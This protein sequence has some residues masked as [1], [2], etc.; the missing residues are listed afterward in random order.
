M[1][2]TQIYTSNIYTIRTILLIHNS[3]THDCIIIKI[4]KQHR[5]SA[6]LLDPGKVPIAET[7]HK[8]KGREVETT[9]PSQYY[10]IIYTFNY[11][12]ISHGN[13]TY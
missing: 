2:D 8:Q 5:L 4:R 7:E 9:N 3:I 11:I 10:T 12:L 13:N 1:C 6:G